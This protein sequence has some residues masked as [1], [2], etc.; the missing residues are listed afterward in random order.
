VAFEPNWF[1]R[2]FDARGLAP[3]D[4]RSG[5]DLG[6]GVSIN[7]LYAWLAIKYAR[8]HAELRLR[9]E[10]DAPLAGRHEFRMIQVRGEGFFFDIA[11]AYEGYSAGIR[12]ARRDAMDRALKSA[13]EGSYVAVA[14]ALEDLPLTAR[15]DHML[16]DGI[17]LLGTGHFAEVQPGI[18][19]ELVSDPSVILE[20]ISSD[21]S[22]SLA[23]VVQGDPSKVQAEALARQAIPGLP[24][25]VLET[26]SRL[27][28]LAEA[29][30]APAVVESIDLPWTNLPSSNLEKL[31]P[32]ISNATAF[33]LRIAEGIFL[34]YR[35]YRFFMY[36][37]TYRTSKL[38]DDDS[39]DQGRWAKLARKEKWAKQVGLT[40]APPMPMPADA[41]DAPVVAVIDSGV[42]YNHWALHS[43][44]WLNPN[45]VSID[46]A[47]VSGKKDY[48]GWDF[49]SGDS[50]PADDGYHGTEVAS[51]IAAV[52]PGAKIMPLKVFNPWG[53]TSSAAIYG[54]FQYA[55][56][57]GAK[58]IVCAWA[59]RLHSQAIEQAVA[60]AREQGVLVVAAAGDRGD[61]LSRVASYPAALSRDFEN[62][63]TVT[64]VD[65]KNQL[66]QVTGHYANFDARRVGI[67]AP[68]EAILA[69]S[70][71]GVKLR[72]SSTGLAAGMVAGAV[73]RELAL[74]SSGGPL[75]WIRRVRS[76]AE[77]IPG[78]RR[79]VQ[80]GLVL[81]IRR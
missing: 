57:H 6:D 71:R 27:D 31:A 73:A 25:P 8:Y 13:I 69:A 52:A 58:I 9:L 55:I 64:G 2:T 62:V 17:I 56:A 43:H 10:I 45:P 50:H 67:A 65:S 37:R 40:E 5:L 34:P 3:F 68:G 19:Y 35:L 61:D 29:Q 46:G 22:G 15:V 51:L 70:P 60:L 7:A 47:E 44:L 16:P 39:T 59:T 75:D 53:I 23:R 36:D 74:D 14:R 38:G 12:V 80:D 20:V 28:A 77:V 72:D 1:D 79:S 21:S 66:V 54:A 18:R 32:Q 81:R 76:Q 49:V 33:F 41:Q 4:S 30:L 24:G 42:D 63:L 26:V 11:G 48:Y 78:L